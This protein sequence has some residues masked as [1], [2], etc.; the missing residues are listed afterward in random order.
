MGAYLNM[1]DM[2]YMKGLIDID[3]RYPPWDK[4]HWLAPFEIS[5]ELIQ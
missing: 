1:L 2:L 4:R 5:E 3:I